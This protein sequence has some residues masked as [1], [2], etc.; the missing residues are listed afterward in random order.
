MI[1]RMELH[2]GGD[3]GYGCFDRWLMLGDAWNW[4]GLLVPFQMSEDFCNLTEDFKKL[5]KVFQ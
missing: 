2:V 4:L 5:T 3:A 1:K